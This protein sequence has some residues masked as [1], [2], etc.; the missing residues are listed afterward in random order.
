MSSAQVGSVRLLISQFGGREEVVRGSDKVDHE[1]W[2]VPALVVGPEQTLLELSLARWTG[3]GEVV[4]NS[5]G[6]SHVYFQRLVQ[7][8][9][10]G[11]KENEFGAGT[12][13]LGLTIWDTDQEWASVKKAAMADLDAALGSSSR[14]LLVAH[15]VDRLDTRAALW[16]DTS[17]RQYYLE[18]QFDPDDPSPPLTIYVLTRVLPVLTAVSE[19]ASR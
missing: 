1:A 3:G 16:G 9:R 11:L 5:R 19:A 8:C 18:A 12:A 13:M 14:N 15:G 10:L 4:M 17:K 6:D 7:G 2:I